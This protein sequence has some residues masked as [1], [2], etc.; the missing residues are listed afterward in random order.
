MKCKIV[1]MS[2]LL[3]FVAS[4]CETN[5][6]PQGVLTKQELVEFLVEM[7]VAE[8]R[9]TGLSIVADSSKKLFHPFEEALLQKSG[10]SDSVMKITYRYY[11]DHPVELEE[12]YDV[13][14]DTLSLREQ[15]E[16][17]KTNLTPLPK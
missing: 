15:K 9:M 1:W 6:K 10:I 14:I 8:A 5:R 17:L 7:Y 13:V 3:A 4:S 11:V 12:V 2:V 16:G